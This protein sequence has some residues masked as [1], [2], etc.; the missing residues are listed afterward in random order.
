VAQKANTRLQS[1]LPGNYSSLCTVSHQAE[2]ALQ[3]FEETL[4]AE[5]SSIVVRDSFA[6]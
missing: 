3:E 1:T 2:N 5:P 6:L 4:K